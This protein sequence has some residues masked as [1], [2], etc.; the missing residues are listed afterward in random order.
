MS[1]GGKPPCLDRVRE[2]HRGTVGCAVGVL[3][4]L[5][6]IRDVVPAEITDGRRDLVVIDVGQQA[7]QVDARDRVTREA[8]AASPTGERSNR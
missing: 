8:V 1:L 7:L 2:H 5:D 6:E 3:V 4:G